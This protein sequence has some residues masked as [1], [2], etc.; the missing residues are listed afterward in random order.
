M[1]ND[2]RNSQWYKDLVERCNAEPNKVHM[3]IVENG[4]LDRNEFKIL[5]DDLVSQFD[6]LPGNSR[7]M[8]NIDGVVTDLAEYKSLYDNENNKDLEDR[9]KKVDFSEVLSQS[10]N[11]KKT[12]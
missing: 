6:L 2:I 11:V 3:A 8:I 10:N 7:V 9:F 4:H 5:L 1:R 12:R